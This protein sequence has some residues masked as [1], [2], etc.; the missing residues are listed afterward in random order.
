MWS[1]YA[2]P[3]SNLILSITVKVTV[4]TK[5]W[6]NYNNKHNL[7]PEPLVTRW[8]LDWINTTDPPSHWKLGIKGNLWCAIGH[9][10]AQVWD[11]TLID[12][13]RQMPYSLHQRDATVIIS[14]NYFT[15]K[16]SKHPGAQRQKQR[17]EEKE[18]KVEHKGT[19]SNVEIKMLFCE[20]AF[21]VAT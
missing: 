18:K 19:S 14:S 20:Q 12:W 7:P 16:R 3:T 11:I 1:S 2:N 8:Q 4:S 21:V 6:F 5:H 9:H 17:K 15:M 13:W 10:S